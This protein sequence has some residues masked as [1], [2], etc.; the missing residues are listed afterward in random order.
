[1][2]VVTTRA[3]VEKMLREVLTKIS[4]LISC[5]TTYVLN[6]RAS[7]LH[8]TYATVTRE[9]QFDLCQSDAYSGL[10]LDEVQG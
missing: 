3:A 9:R 10:H 1:M 7:N 8:R 6:C 4:T 2:L 5:T